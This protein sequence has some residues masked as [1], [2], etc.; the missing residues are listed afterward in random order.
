MK[1]ALEV[2]PIQAKIINTLLFQTQGRFSQLNP[3]RLPTDQFSFHLRSLTEAG[4]I[5]K[6]DDGLYRLTTF[7]KEFAGRFDTDRAVLEKQAKISVVVYC[8]RTHKGVTRYLLHER[9]KQ[10]YFGYVGPPG[11]KVRWGETA[12]D[13]AVRELA[14]E[15]G[16]TAASVTPLRVKHKMDFTPDG[17][18]AE[19][20]Y[21]IV[22]KTLNPAGVLKDSVPGGK[23]AWYTLSEIAGLPLVFDD[24]DRTMSAFRQKTLT[25]TESKYTVAGF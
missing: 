3:D 8:A 14:E 1:A 13:A 6:S 15:T 23:N 16:L 17:Q 11:G 2:H 9:L 24:F 20:K 22:F 12:A 10:P 18:L 4:L 25:F 5:Y 21:F 19:D 7:G